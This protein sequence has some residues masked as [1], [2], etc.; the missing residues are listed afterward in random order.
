MRLPALSD[1]RF[2]RLAPSAP[3]GSPRR[4]SA[5]AIREGSHVD[6]VL[7]EQLNRPEPAALE[8]VHGHMHR[9]SQMPYTDPTQ[10]QY[11]PSHSHRPNPMHSHTHSHSHSHSPPAHHSQLSHSRHSQSPHP[12]YHASPSSHPPTSP[13][14]TFHPDHHASG[15]SWAADAR[16]GGGEG[17]RLHPMRSAQ[18]VPHVDGCLM[19]PA[20]VLQQV[21]HSLLARPRSSA[22]ITCDKT[23]AALCDL[24]SVLILLDEDL[25]ATE[26][27]SVVLFQPVLNVRKKLAAALHSVA[28]PLDTSQTM[29][30]RT[31]AG[32]F[33]REPV[34]STG[35][36]GDGVAVHALP[37]TQLPTAPVPEGG[38]LIAAS[39]IHARCPELSRQQPASSI[40]ATPTMDAAEMAAAITN[41]VMLH[42]STCL[43]CASS[44]ASLVAAFQALRAAR[45]MVRAAGAGAHDLL[46]QPRTS[47]DCAQPPPTP[48]HPARPPATASAPLHL[49]SLNAPQP[50]HQAMPAQGPT[51]LSGLAPSASS[52][53]Q[54]FVQGQA[55]EGSNN[56]VLAPGRAKRGA[57]AWPGLATPADQ[58]PPVTPQAAE[59]EAARGVLAGGEQGVIYF[60]IWKR[61]RE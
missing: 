16:E 14:Q 24:L 12:H 38:P 25:Q 27:G 32:G 57:A 51:P 40:T 8:H 36:A 9:H 31:A 43:R 47:L 46:A 39:V 49:H 34:P 48:A 7:I 59:T 10:Q 54:G 5:A 55:V 58:A 17:S 1:A 22:L 56:I 52:S 23:S 33:A 11:P 3:V 42:G 37:S 60:N 21:R 13:W 35:T 53:L 18:L 28:A 20:V 26:P 15:A 44:P 19:D 41:N 29:Q 2:R 45:L 61:A 6:E 30:A 50:T 4:V